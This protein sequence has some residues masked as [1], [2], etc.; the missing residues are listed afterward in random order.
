MHPIFVNIYMKNGPVTVR[1]IYLCAGIFRFVR[2]KE[3]FGL[4]FWEYRGLYTS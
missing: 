4:L 1:Y 3:T 2:V